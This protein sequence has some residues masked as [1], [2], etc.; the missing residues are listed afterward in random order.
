MPSAFFCEWKFQIRIKT[1][2]II[3]INISHHERLS[4][5]SSNSH[6]WVSYASLPFPA[7]ISH[8]P[9]DWFPSL[10][11]HERIRK[12]IQDES[13]S[14]LKINYNKLINQKDVFKFF[15]T[16]ELYMQASKK[17]IPLANFHLHHIPKLPDTY[18]LTIFVRTFEKVSGRLE[19]RQ[20]VWETVRTFVTYTFFGSF[21]LKIIF[22]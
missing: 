5:T 15:L 1:T 12:D 16:F 20:V 19:N 17:A 3:I 14:E 22:F 11:R 2:E 4:S 6:A 13:S 9:N 10:S 18:D 7:L 21:S 8:L